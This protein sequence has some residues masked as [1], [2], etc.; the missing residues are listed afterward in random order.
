MPASKK[1]KKAS[2]KQRQDRTVDHV[3]NLMHH[4]ALELMVRDRFLALALQAHPGWVLE[5]IEEADQWAYMPSVPA[6]WMIAFHPGGPT[7][8]W[9]DEDGYTV[10]QAWAHDGDPETHLFAERGELL[11]AL[12]EI[13]SWEAPFETE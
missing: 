13:E 5:S 4:G 3:V 7:G 2:M 6:D 10:S 9:V 1:R 11:A 12:P 8:I